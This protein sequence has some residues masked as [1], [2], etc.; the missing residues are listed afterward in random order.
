[1][2]QP[3]KHLI[4]FVYIFITPTRIWSCNQKKPLASFTDLID[5]GYFVSV[6]KGVTIGPS[7]AAAAA[8]A[9]SIILEIIL[10][11]R[12]WRRRNA[13]GGTNRSLFYLDKE[14]LR[15]AEYKQAIVW[16]EAISGSVGD[17]SA[18]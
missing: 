10:V 18:A 14:R 7:A 9:V 4:F 6:K 2:E 5:F 3:R 11:I 13:T 12:G 15:S 17:K 1:M 8:A 16:N